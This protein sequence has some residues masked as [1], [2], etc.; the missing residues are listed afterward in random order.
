[1]GEIGRALMLLLSVVYSLVLSEVSSLCIMPSCQSSSSSSAFLS[2]VVC[3]ASLCVLEASYLSSYD[4]GYFFS[5]RH[6]FLVC[7][8]LLQFIDA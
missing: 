6:L 8:K 2:A 7:S 3:F 5:V 1:M 4:R